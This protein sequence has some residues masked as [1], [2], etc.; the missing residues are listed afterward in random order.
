[1]CIRDRFC[2][3]VRQY[4]FLLKVAGI[5]L[6]LIALK[7]VVAPTAL[8]QS[9][10]NL[11]DAVLYKGHKEQGLLGSRLTPWQRSLDTIKKHPLFGT[12]YG[13]SPTGEDSTG[14][15]RYA[16]YARTVG[17]HGSSYATI[18]Q[19]VGLLG[20]LPFLMLV[21][22][23][24]VNAGRVFVWMRRTSNPYHYSVPLAM[25]LLAGLVHANFED[26]L[27]AVGSYLSVF[28]WFVS[29]ILVDL[30]PVGAEVPFR[31]IVP[32]VPRPATAS[33]RVLAPGR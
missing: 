25:V 19:W 12:G 9:A 22:L 5:F 15:T 32:S 8:I 2:F 7:G 3:S 29:F 31:R 4:K 20:G 30:L 16:S 18:A 14:F 24:A 6:C 21:A 28:F 33:L 1:M 23:T 27:F 11:K 10:E 13:T 26:W 17:E